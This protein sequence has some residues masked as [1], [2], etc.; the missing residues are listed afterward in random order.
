[1]LSKQSIRKNVTIYLNNELIE[2]DVLIEMSRD[3]S[4]R[5][6]GLVRKMIKQE[7]KV[8]IQGNLL[9]FVRTDVRI[10]NSKGEFESLNIKPSSLSDFDF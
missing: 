10:R 1:M 6:L 8:K 9:Q 4:E 2:K 5:E 7:G 3:Y